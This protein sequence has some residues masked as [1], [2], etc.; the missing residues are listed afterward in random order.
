MLMWL[1]RNPKVALVSLSADSS[2][3][4]GQ[5]GLVHI[6]IRSSTFST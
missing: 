1:A 5:G 4:A 6:L 3:N 2:R